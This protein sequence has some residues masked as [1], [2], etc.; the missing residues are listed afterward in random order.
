MLPK[1]RFADLEK[2]LRNPFTVTHMNDA[3]ILYDP[4][5]FLAKM[6]N[7]V[8]AVF[9]EPKWLGIRVWHWP[10]RGFCGALVLLPSFGLG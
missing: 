6:Q 7:R 5:R 3:L 2:V 10:Q 4:T 8:R 1:E 9:M